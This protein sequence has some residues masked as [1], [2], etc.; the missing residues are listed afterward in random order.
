MANESRPKNPFTTIGGFRTY[1][2]YAKW[3]G[4][5]KIGRGTKPRIVGPSGIIIEDPQAA[6]D[7]SK[8]LK[9]A[10]AVMRTIIDN[11]KRTENRMKELFEEAQERARREEEERKRRHAEARRTQKDRNKLKLDIQNWLE[12]EEK[13]FQE[14]KKKEDKR[15]AEWEAYVLSLAG[16][17]RT[18]AKFSAGVNSQLSFVARQKNPSEAMHLLRDKL[19]KLSDLYRIEKPTKETLEQI[20][21]LKSTVEKIKKVLDEKV[22]KTLEDL[23]EKAVATKKWQDY[24]SEWQTSWEGFKDRIIGKLTFRGTRQ[25]ISNWFNNLAVVRASK[26]VK[27]VGSAFLQHRREMRDADI[28]ARERAGVVQDPSWR[29]LFAKDDDAAILHT[30]AP[31]PRLKGPAG[32]IQ[33]L[34]QSKSEKLME[35]FFRNTKEYRHKVLDLAQKQVQ[36]AKMAGMAGIRGGKIGK[37]GGPGSALLGFIGGLLGHIAQAA[38]AKILSLFK[39]IPAAI[40]GVLGFF[41]G[42]AAGAAGGLASLLKSPLGSLLRAAGVIG[43]GYLGWQVGKWLYEEYAPQILDFVSLVADKFNGFRKW[44]DELLGESEK[45]RREKFDAGQAQVQSKMPSSQVHMALGREG[46]GGAAFGFQGGSNPRPAAGKLGSADASGL[47]A[48]EN[49][50]AATSLADKA[51]QFISGGQSQISELSSANQERV[52]KLAESYHR[53]TGKR[54]QIEAFKDPMG[55]GFRV[56]NN[57]NIPEPLLQQYGFDRSASDP[58]LIKAR[59]G[60]THSMP[61]EYKVPET[62]LAPTGAETTGGATSKAGRGSVGP[63]QKVGVLQI[64]NHM[65]VDGTHFAMQVGMF[66]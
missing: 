43:A 31:K 4:T 17:Q 18:R 36:S 60:N 35:A 11:T 47:R 34:P 59:S 28:A 57:T 13:E 30:S 14:N 55:E 41:G 8:H 23:E 37:D 22:S 1:E 19:T 10:G 53:M 24:T 48:S 15:K 3:L 56:R 51:K 5:T 64:P 29:S 46:E 45:S 27:N 52:V 44:V 7:L 38:L 40:K 50:I 9:L 6:Q 32:V 42:A 58:R 61:Q 20:T 12:E 63:N 33:P 62:S 16:Y 21:K 25:R 65:D 49:T 39:G 54:L 26:Y 2:E 66:Q